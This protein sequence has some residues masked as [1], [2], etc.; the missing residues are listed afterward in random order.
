MINVYK[1]NSTA[2]AEDNTVQKEFIVRLYKFW[3]FDPNNDIPNESAY[4]L[5]MLQII[6]Y[7]NPIFTGLVNKFSN[8]ND[9]YPREHLDNMSN[10]LIESKFV[11]FLFSYSQVMLEKII[12]LE[13]GLEN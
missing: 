11:Y 7:N 9:V 13:I 6:N 3:A 5:K 1:L 8:K 10:Y 2:K 12:K 4:Y